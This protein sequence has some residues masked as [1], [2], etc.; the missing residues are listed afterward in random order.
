MGTKL[1]GRK[2]YQSSNPSYSIKRIKLSW[3]ENIKCKKA[4]KRIFKIYRKLILIKFILRRI[5]QE[6]T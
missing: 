6:S 3:L 1:K 2:A 5:K 4:K